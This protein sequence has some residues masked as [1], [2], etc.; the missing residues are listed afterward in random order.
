MKSCRI[1]RRAVAFAL[2]LVMLVALAGCSQ[3]NGSE[4]TP[5]TVTLL[6]VGK[7]DAVVALSG[8]HALLIDAGEEDDGMDVVEFLQKHSVQEVDAMI[9]THYDQD[10]VGGADTVLEQI[11]V[12]TV[13]V[14]DYEG[15]HMEYL[16]FL[17]AA[18]ETNVPVQRLNESVSFRFG[19]ADV[20]IEPPES[21]DIPNTNEDYD[22]NFSLITTVTHGENRLVFMGDAEKLRIRD[23]MKGNNAVHC[24]FLKV[25]H[26]GVYNGALEELFAALTPDF[27]VICS[28]KKNPAERKTL[29]L[30]KNYSPNVFETKDG[31]VLVI[32]NGKKLEVQQK[33]K[34]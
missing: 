29:E 14:P 1:G 10:H 12:K 19:D 33:Y 6:K 2:S 26:H 17:R 4:L 20:L 32:S 30:L 31:K 5:L 13:Y 3:N 11:P 28:S 23:W 9:I 7:A 34:R 16:D 25:P 22:N 21:Y 18:E 27:S 8:S 24:D 15:T